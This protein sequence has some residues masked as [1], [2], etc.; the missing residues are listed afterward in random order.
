MVE[1]DHAFLSAHKFYGPKGIGA[2]FIREGLELPAMLL[3]GGQERGRRAGTEAVHQ[4][5]GMGAAAIL[6][7]D[8]TKMEK[9]SHVRDKLEEGILAQIPAS[10]VNGSTED[11]LRLPNTTNISFENTNGEMIL[12]K[13]NEIGICVSTGSACNSESKTSSPV[14]AAMDVPYSRTMGSIG[15]R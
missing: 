8:L 9:V 6:G 2:L 1:L 3:G 4:I 11:E 7:S 5:V 14:L 15:F 12:H 10:F 13:L